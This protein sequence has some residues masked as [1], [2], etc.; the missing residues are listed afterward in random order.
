MNIYKIVLLLEFWREIQPGD[1]EKQIKTVSL[2]GDFLI[3]Q[4]LLTAHKTLTH[5]W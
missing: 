3:I 2:E 4:E 1:F 5:F